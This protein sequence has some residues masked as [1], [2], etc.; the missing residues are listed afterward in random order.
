MN[1]CHEITKEF[2]KSIAEAFRARFE[3]DRKAKDRK[4]FES[5][6]NETEDRTF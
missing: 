1:G 2:R 5:D 4:E 6:L 3:S